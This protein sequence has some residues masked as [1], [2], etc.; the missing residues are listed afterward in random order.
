MRLKSTLPRGDSSSA[1]PNLQVGCLAP[2]GLDCTE[3]NITYLSDRITPHTPGLVPTNTHEQREGALVPDVEQ[4][5]L[6]PMQLAF[7]QIEQDLSKRL[8]LG[9]SWQEKLSVAQGSIRV[10]DSDPHSRF[11]ILLGS[12][13]F[14]VVMLNCQ[15]PFARSCFAKVPSCSASLWKATPLSSFPLRSPALCSRFYFEID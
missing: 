4:A 11:P 13:S 6:P 3:S 5:V 10:D 2:P 7:P 12:N 15:I 1:S 9:L 14:P 8:S